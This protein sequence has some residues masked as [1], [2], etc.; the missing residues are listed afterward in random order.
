[1]AD[2]GLR[3][4]RDDELL[5]RRAVLAEGTL[6]LELDPLA[7]ER[8]A[9]ERQRAVRAR[10]A[11][12]QLDADRDPGLDG[13]A[14]AADPASSCSFLTRRRSSKKRWSAV[15]SIPFARR[16]SAWPSGKPAGVTAARGRAPA[17]AEVELAVEGVGVEP[18]LEQLV[19]AG[20]L[21]REHLEPGS[22]LADPAASSELTTTL[23]FPPT[24]A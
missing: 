18:A 16:W 11:A 6:D 9:A 24:S 7:G 1:M 5:G 10:G 17:G 20:I 8:L 3:A 23:R 19:D 2:R 4:V 13:A 12:Q 22:E 15:S 14:G 21:E